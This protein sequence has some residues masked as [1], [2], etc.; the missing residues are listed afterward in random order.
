MS[1]LDSTRDDSVAYDGPSLECPT[2]V[3]G[4][5]ST[6]TMAIVEHLAA[7]TCIL[8]SVTLFDEGEL[9]TFTLTVQGAPQVIVSGRV[10]ERSSNGPRSRYALNLD[11]MTVGQREDIARLTRE[12][13]YRRSIGQPMPD[14]STQNGL[15]RSSVR[16]PVDIP[17]RY[18]IEGRES[19]DARA[20]NLSAGGVL[21]VCAADLAVG[22]ALDLAFSLS[23]ETQ[24]HPQIAIQA[25]IV[26]RQPLRSGSYSYNLAFHGADP[27]VRSAI[28]HHVKALLQ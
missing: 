6:P 8:R 14:V 26:A 11:P 13:T 27:S 18:A 17:V 5:S 21:I 15:T 28:E 25:R 7:T 2:M 23:Q 12:A 20:T 24:G 3:R 19:G 22:S 9:L 16:V 1:L 4:T 10:A